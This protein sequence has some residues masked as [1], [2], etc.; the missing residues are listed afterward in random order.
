MKDKTLEEKIAQDIVPE[1]ESDNFDPSLQEN[2]ERAALH[3]TIVDVLT[4]LKAI[5]DKM[6]VS[7]DI[8]N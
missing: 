2:K 4:R 1:V 8:I 3:D 7:N 5:E 6:G